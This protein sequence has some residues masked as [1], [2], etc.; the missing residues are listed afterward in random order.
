MTNPLISMVHSSQSVKN[1]YQRDSS[2]CPCDCSERAEQWKVRRHMSQELC[3]VATNDVICPCNCLRGTSR[4]KVP[5]QKR[6]ASRRSTYPKKALLQH[7]IRVETPEL[8][9]L[10]SGDFYFG[11]QKIQKIIGR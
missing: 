11:N 7:P 5:C 1:S 4:W 6:S 9:P 3:S 10:E 2:T 8:Q